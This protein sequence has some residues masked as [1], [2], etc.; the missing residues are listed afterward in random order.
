MELSQRINITLPD[1]S[2]EKDAQVQPSDPL[3][4]VAQLIEE[5]TGVDA[6][7]VTE[8]ATPEALGIDSLAR[9][10]L[11]VRAEEAFGVRIEAADAE[12]FETIGDYVA[13]LAD[14]E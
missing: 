3:E 6:E 5:V 1:E 14:H 9:I 10:E 11:V 2:S 13:Y 4:R 7:K 12:G 8:D